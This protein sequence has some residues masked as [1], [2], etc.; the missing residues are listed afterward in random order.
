MVR[1]PGPRERESS[2][3]DCFF[4]SDLHGRPGRYE[5]LWERVKVERPAALFLGGDLL[6]MVWDHTW[7]REGDTG[8]F[9]VDRVFPALAAL[10][11][12]LGD[13]YPR[14]FAIPG[15]DDPRCDEECFAEG[16]SRG[17]WTYLHQRCVEFAGRPVLGY[18]CVPPTPFQLK[19]W[20]R[21]DVS[22]FVDPGCLSPEEGKRTVALPEHD[23]R[24]G[25][26]A[27]DLAAL[28]GDRD[29]GEAICLFHT[30]P[31]DTVLDRAAL[32]GK[33]V[34][35]APLDVHVGSIAVQRFLA[36]RQPAVSL[37]GHIHEA[38][39]L[40]GHW[41]QQIG[42]TWCLGGSH[43]G[44]ELALVRFDPAAPAAATRELIPPADV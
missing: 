12:S 6:P 11:T 34:D 42:R 25:T 2:V 43:D 3:R 39:R 17:L 28:A 19:D 10:R 38:A 15:N 14:I 23:V 22:R 37:H 16:E 21:Y 13:D 35:H 1:E 33:F 41:R 31:Y 8:E 30:P 40:T 26:I 44:P 7:L 24:Y 4:V 20:E 36:A 9:L 5:R 29:L 27:A 18:A 32:D